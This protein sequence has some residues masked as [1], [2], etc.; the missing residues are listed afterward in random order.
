MRRAARAAA[1]RT[2]AV[3]GRAGSSQY[4]PSLANIASR[5][6]CASMTRQE[7]RGV[8]PRRASRRPRA[9]DVRMP[10]RPPPRRRRRRRRRAR[11]TGRATGSVP[12]RPASVM[13]SIPAARR[14]S[15]ARSGAFPAAVSGARA[16]GA[17]AQHPV[18]AAP[19]GPF[20]RAGSS[21]N[22]ASGRF[23]ER[24]VERD[25]V[26]AA[27]GAVRSR[28]HE[29]L[30]EQLA[31]RLVVAVQLA[32]GSDDHERRLVVGERSRTPGAARG[33]PG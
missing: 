7:H 30:E 31:E 10:R 27:H 5:Q 1:R 33:P 29:P 12:R 22:A 14:S 18:M 19:R 21:R 24:L 26:E 23:V 32:V 20:R 9:S 13:T 4:Q 28:L 2:P 16:V 11:P 15:A 17:P 25:D 6:R 8:A 3:S